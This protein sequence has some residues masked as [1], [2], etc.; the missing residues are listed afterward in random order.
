MSRREASAAAA[1][2]VFAALGDE[3][4]IKLV[5]RLSAGG[6]A[7]IAQLTAGSGV[8]RQAVAKHLRVLAGAGLVKGIRRGR[9][10]EWKL[11]PQRL[12]DARRSL[13]QIAQQWG[14][15]LVRLRA[16]VEADG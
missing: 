12:E 8:T 11:E 2:P 5:A 1:A 6:P 9:E 13:E 3:T 4:R 10:S 16:F 14:A 15:A 7:S